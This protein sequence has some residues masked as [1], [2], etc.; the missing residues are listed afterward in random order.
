[1]SRYQSGCS[2]SG[3]SFDP[4]QQLPVLWTYLTISKKRYRTWW[5]C[6]KVADHLLEP[7]VPSSGSSA[8]CTIYCS[9]GSFLTPGDMQQ[10]L[11][12]RPANRLTPN[13]LTL[14]T[15]TVH[16]AH[17]WSR[18]PT[19]CIH[20][21]SSGFEPYGFTASHFSICLSAPSPSC[22]LVY[23]DAAQCTTHTWTPEHKKTS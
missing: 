23:A 14:I 12:S 5:K 15:I 3:I 17:I 22:L 9:L 7:P 10:L 18:L 6:G 2:M 16:P 11:R 21:M 13:R 1:M 19:P 8:M 20:I 4:L